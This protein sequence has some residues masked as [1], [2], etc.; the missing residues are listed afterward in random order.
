M[1]DVESLYTAFADQPRPVAVAACPHCRDPAEF[2][3]LVDVPL[4][5]LEDELLGRFL[6]HS[7]TIGTPADRQWLA[8]RLIELVVTGQCR[9]LGVEPTLHAIAGAGWATWPAPQ[10]A[11]V[12]SVL[13]AFWAATL[14]AY[15]GSYPAGDVLSGLSA[16]VTSV[17]PYLASWVPTSTPA[18]LHLRDLVATGAGPVLA[19]NRLASPYWTPH[20]NVAVVAWLRSAELADGVT[21]AILAATDQVTVATLDEVDG[22]LVAFR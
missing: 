9:Y 3:R 4:R 20:A 1:P 22:Y 8:P 21:A 7:G 5:L 10:R 12:T 14:A 16:L 2:A 18:A 13:D 19:K 15:P 17:E 11:T 6:A